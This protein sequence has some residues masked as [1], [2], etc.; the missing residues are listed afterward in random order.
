MTDTRGGEG[1]GIEVRHFSSAGFQ[2]TSPIST[3][4]RPPVTFCENRS[5]DRIAARWL[6]G[7]A[8]ETRDGRIH[9]NG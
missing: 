2:S 3:R 9:E 4:E 7:S 6:L 8:G 1:S 5:Y